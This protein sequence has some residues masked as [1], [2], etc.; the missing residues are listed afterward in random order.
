MSPAESALPEVEEYLRVARAMRTAQGWPS[1]APAPGSIHELRSRHGEA[2]ISEGHLARLAAEIRGLRRIRDNHEALLARVQ[3]VGITTSIA[4]EMIVRAGPEEQG[5]LSQ[6]V[7]R[8]MLRAISDRLDEHV[9]Y[10]V[11]RDPL[12][13]LHNVRGVLYVIAPEEPAPLALHSSPKAIQP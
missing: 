6:S 12:R 4:D 10:T 11:E 1:G 2:V 13:C 3:K 9:E 5:H 8:N 7:K